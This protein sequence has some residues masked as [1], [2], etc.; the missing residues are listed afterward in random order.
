MNEELEALV[1]ELEAAG[2]T[3]EEITAIL[4]E[5]L[6]S[7][8][9]NATPTGTTP[10][11][12]APQSNEEFGFFDSIKGAF[13][14]VVDAYNSPRDP[15]IPEPTDPVVSAIKRG[16]ASGKQADILN[17]GTTVTQ[18][19]AAQLAG[20]QQKIQSLPA[21]QTYN[22]FVQ[23][24]KFNDAISNFMEDPLSITVQ[25]TAESLS[26]MAAH[27]LPIMAERAAEGGVMGAMYGTAVPGVGNV[28]GALGGAG[29]GFTVGMAET[30]LDLEYASKFL[31]TL[32][33]SGVDLSNPESLKKA[34][35]DEKLLAEARKKGLQKGI[36]I[37]AF[38]LISG[39][40]AGKIMSKPAKSII[41][42]VGQGIAEMGV[43]GGLGMAGEAAGQ[44]VAGE[45]LSAG[46]ILAEGFGELASAPTQAAVGSRTIYNEQR[47]EARIC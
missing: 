10:T 16:I 8:N 28:A 34:F 15:S 7:Q 27:G 21:T 35:Q 42:R 22:N 26:A 18:E 44:T 1:A 24:T 43:Q 13:N 45:E 3:D 38:D 23:A 39:G 9:K 20:L 5:R 46:S 25:L 2:A 41:G 19:G 11:A 12:Q 6:A 32:Q 4:E 31:E 33:E 29:A 36:P 40:I 17:P 14:E 47:Q 37:A 30:S